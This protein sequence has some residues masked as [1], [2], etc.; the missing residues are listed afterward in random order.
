MHT[1]KSKRK[2]GKTRG[3]G[4][5]LFEYV[6]KD[7]RIH[8][9]ISYTARG[10]RVREV[11]G[12]S[13]KFAATMLAKR[14]VE[15]AEGKY[16]FPSRKKAMA[17]EKLCQKYIEYAQ[18]HKRSW[19]R[20][21]GVIKK[22]ILFFGNTSVER[23]TQWDVERYKANSG[24]TVSKASVN[25]ELAILKRMLR[26]AVQWG[27][28]GS[29]PAAE[30]KLYREEEQPMRVVSTKEEQILIRAAASH[31][32]PIIVMALNT[33]MR[34]GEILNMKWT[35]I[36]LHEQVIT[37]TRTKSGRVRHIPINRAVEATLRAF[38]GSRDGY[39][40]LWRGKHVQSV[41]RAFK[42]AVRVSGIKSCRFHDLRH[43]FA[44]R[45]VLGGIDIVTV[46]ELLGHADISMTMRYAHPSPESKKRALRTLD[47]KSD[48]DSFNLSL[49]NSALKI[50]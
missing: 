46:K 24:K 19:K 20:D 38:K 30:V 15:L 21:A 14:K 43:T 6:T 27:F 13:K 11:V 48:Q 28:L 33:G 37:V 25:R 3:L 39:V 50:S 32:K 5:G 12:E 35:H 29:N 34:R 17:V 31:L 10:R 49:R 45:L 7:G 4:R 18:Q 22:I 41:S 42:T 23:I 40:F 2:P 9:G 8:Y 44:M 47:R 26:L 1:K 36:D 16:Q